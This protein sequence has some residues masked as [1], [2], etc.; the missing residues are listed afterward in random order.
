MTGITAGKNDRKDP[1][2]VHEQANKYKVA[3][4][5]QQSE[6]KFAP[7]AQ[8]SSLLIRR[9]ATPIRHTY[10]PLASEIFTHMLLKCQFAS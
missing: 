5:A 6:F 4:R 7:S 2:S 8:K 10:L 3:R 9:I 1:G